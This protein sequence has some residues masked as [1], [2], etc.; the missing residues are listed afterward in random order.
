MII[1]SNDLFDG[2][3]T[4]GDAMDL[5]DMSGEDNVSPEIVE[6]L[7]GMDPEDVA[8]DAIDYP[9]MMGF[10]I[11]TIMKRRKMRRALRRKLKHLPRRKRRRII[12]KMMAKGKGKAMF[13][14]APG[15]FPGSRIFRALAL[16][17]FSKRGQRRA[18]RRKKRFL[19]KRKARRVRRRTAKEITPFRTEEFAPAAVEV[20]EQPQTQREEK[21]QERMLPFPRTEQVEQYGPEEAPAAKPDFMKFL[22]LVAAAA[23]IPFILPKK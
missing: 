15:I 17:R 19:A 4:S 10:L 13:M 2:C 14:M 18:V 5:V 6:V 23:V 11:R 7:N 21:M 1:E 8:Q 12:A 16:R 20:E 9:E 22:P 3:S